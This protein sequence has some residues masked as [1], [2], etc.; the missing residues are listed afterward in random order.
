MKKE[1]IRQNFLHI[2]TVMNSAKFKEETG[3]NLVYISQAYNY[4]NS[5]QE[6]HETILDVYKHWGESTPHFGGLGPHRFEGDECIYCLR[7]QGIALEEIEAVIKML[8]S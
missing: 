8:E 5:I 7:P 2:N 1:N 3:L 4:L 6:E